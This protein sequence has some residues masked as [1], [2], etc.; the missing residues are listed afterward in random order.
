MNDAL[1][2]FDYFRINTLNTVGMLN[3]EVQV[4]TRMIS[5]RQIMTSQDALV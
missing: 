4:T 1:I 2:L 5:Y 3:P